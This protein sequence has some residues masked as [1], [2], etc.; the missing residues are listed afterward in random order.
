M[1]S[2]FWPG[3][4]RAGDVM[5]DAAFLRALA[6][7]EDRWLLVLAEHGV[8]PRYVPIG[9]L[10]GESDLPHLTTDA[11]S[12]GNP[13]IPAVALLRERLRATGNPDAAEWLHRGL[14]SQDVV[15]TALMLCARD[16]VGRV[17]GE[18]TTQIRLL[19]D[20]ADAHRATPMAARTLTQPAVPTTFGAK[21]ATWLHGLLDADDALIARIYPVQ[22]GGAAGT[23]SG[24]VELAGPSAAHSCRTAFPA[25]LGLAAAVPWHTHRAT[26]TALGDAAVRA[27]DSWGRIAN[28][29]LTLTRPEIGELAQA[30]PGG[31]S[32]MPH[33]ANPTLPILI[34]R[35]ALAAP[36]LGATLHIAAGEQVDERAD[37]AWHLEWGTLAILLRRTVVAAA[38]TSVLLTGLRV[39]TTRMARRV[40]EIETDLHAEQR[41]MAALAG[42]PPH[43]TYQGLADDLVQEA[44][45]RARTHLQENA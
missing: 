40:A 13:V 6:L 18:L 7:T 33:K 24:L 28:D 45:D 5:S 15:D 36:A 9:D 42:H 44:V 41:G 31:S 27:N 20:L 26:I 8:A 17:R 21:V 14:T 11:E 1:N 30:D 43:P 39:N 22:L 16:A 34:R 4:H 19:T 29:V 35:A 10:V 12:G 23:L 38:Q 37:G 2:L 3:D 25:A 32:T